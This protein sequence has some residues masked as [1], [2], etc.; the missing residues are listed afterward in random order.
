MF[1]K[2][3]RSYFS[4]IRELNKLSDKELHDI[5]ISRKNINKVAREY[6]YKEEK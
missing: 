4:T 2:K 6:S 1:F 5:G 3:Y